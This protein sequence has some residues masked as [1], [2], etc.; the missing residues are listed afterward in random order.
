MEEDLIEILEIITSNDPIEVSNKIVKLSDGVNMFYGRLGGTANGGFA[1]VVGE[2]EYH[3]KLRKLKGE[4]FNQIKSIGLMRF[5][6]DVRI[7][8]KQE[9]NV[10]RRTSTK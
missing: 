6:R 4:G 5:K 9:Y 7:L 2:D 8:L 1:A 10:V 3:L